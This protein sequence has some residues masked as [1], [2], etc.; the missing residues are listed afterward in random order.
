MLTDHAE[1]VDRLEAI[2]AS[3]EAL[4]EYQSGNDP[5]RVDTDLIHSL[6]Q[7]ICGEGRFRGDVRA[8]FSESHFPLEFSV[9]SVPP[10]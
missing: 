6:L 5:N 8:L 10:P 2:G 7:Y 1:V 4:K 3:S 9:Y